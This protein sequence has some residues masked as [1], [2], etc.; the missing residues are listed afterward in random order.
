[1]Y[2]GSTL[3]MTRPGEAVRTPR[4]TTWSSRQS[5]TRFSL[6]LTE[7]HLSPLYM[8][9]ATSSPTSVHQRCTLYTIT[10]VHKAIRQKQPAFSF[11][12]FQPNQAM[13]TTDVYWVEYKLS[14]WRQS[15]YYRGSFIISF[16]IVSLSQST[17]QC[18]RKKPRNGSWGTFQFCHLKSTWNESW[19]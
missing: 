6:A 1:M 7:I 16:Q 18:S 4:I 12:R 11:S 14:I 15:F 10:S 13:H 2:G 17:Y 19:A 9:P 5:W 3:M 8:I